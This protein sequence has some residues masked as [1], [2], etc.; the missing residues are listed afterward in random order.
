MEY[1]ELN[2]FVSPP[3]LPLSSVCSAAT[4][5]GA[6]CCPNPGLLY[7]QIKDAKSFEEFWVQ[8][9]GNIIDD[10]LPKYLLELLNAKGLSR[11]DVVV[12]TGLDK[13]YAYQIFA[14]IRNPSRDKLI[15]I[16]FGMGLSEDET[17]EMLKLSGHREL[18]PRDERDALFLYAI[19]R[20]MSLEDV[21]SQ[22]KRYGLN[23]L[24]PPI[25]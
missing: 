21:D 9:K 2:P 10:P 22:L 14:G 24:S 17:Q 13:A 18:W 20:G 25:K 23:P 4:L 15:T 19:Q 5:G 8:N 7:Q 16:A 12:K 3:V 1:E 11:A 6:I